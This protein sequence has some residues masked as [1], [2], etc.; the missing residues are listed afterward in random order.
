MDDDW[1][2]RRRTGWGYLVDVEMALL[3]HTHISISLKAC[4]A[5]S[6]NFFYDQSPFL[7]SGHGS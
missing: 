5:R 6:N 1:R 4:A 7:R 3:L 2:R